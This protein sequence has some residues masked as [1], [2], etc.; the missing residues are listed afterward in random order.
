MTGFSV[1]RIV[2]PPL[3][4]PTLKGGLTIRP[5]SMHYRGIAPNSFLERAG[6]DALHC[7]AQY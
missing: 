3:R 7:R 1:G 5:I 4:N 6:R 2:N